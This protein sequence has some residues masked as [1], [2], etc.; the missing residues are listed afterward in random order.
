MGDEEVDKG[1]EGRLDRMFAEAPAFGDAELFALRVSD[2]LDR[3]W[4]LRGAAIGALGL[5]GGM[6]V[7]VQA[8][9]SGVIARAQSLPH[10]SSA[11]IGRALDHVLPWRLSISGLPFGGELVWIPAALAA[12]ALG[13]VVVRAI[14]EI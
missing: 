13:F 7:V 5:V 4:T 14:R 10:H 1:F 2:R 6:V 11:A 12:L 8:A 3:G 9:S